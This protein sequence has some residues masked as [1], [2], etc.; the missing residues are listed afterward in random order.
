MFVLYQ[1]YFQ[2]ND[3]FFNYIKI[4]VIPSFVVLQ[5]DYNKKK[6]SIVFVSQLIVFFLRVL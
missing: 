3:S 2:E 6:L 4:V 5:I 1:S